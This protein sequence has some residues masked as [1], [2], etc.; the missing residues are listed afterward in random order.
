MAWFVLIVSAVFEAV[1]ATA[2]GMSEGFTKPWP[3]IVFLVALT[4]SM[5]G[6]GWAAKSIPMGT[7]YAVWTGI[8]AA[9]TVTYA[10][11][12]GSEPVS[13]L[14]IVFLVGIIA[15]VIGLKLVP[16]KEE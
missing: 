14:K 3:T 5:L 16:T 2:L 6:L 12:T 10:M 8:G 1:W 11:L 15:A 4:L 13:A 7:A 9:L